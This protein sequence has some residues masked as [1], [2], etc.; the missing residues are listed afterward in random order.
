[1]SAGPEKRDNP[2]VKG[3]EEKRRLRLLWIILLASLGVHVVAGL[4]FGSI[5]VFRHIFKKETTFEAPPE[6]VRTIDP[7]KIEHKVKVREQQQSSGRPQVQ[8]RLAANKVSQ[9]SLP[10][11]DIQSA[12]VKD[13]LQDRITQNFATAGV[14]TGLGTGAGS[15]GLGT[16]SSSVNFFGLQASGER[17]AFLVDVSRSMVEDPKG[18]V[19]G[20]TVLKNEL[21]EMIDKLNDGTFFNVIFFDA[22]VDVLSSSKFLIAN[23]DNKAKAKELIDRY[24]E[25]AEYSSHEKVVG[26]NG[27]SFREATILR[28]FRPPGMESTK[29][30]I[31]SGSTRLDYA[32]LA[33]FQQKADTI[34][35]IADGRPELYRKLEGAELEEFEKEKEK[36]IK[37]AEERR[38]IFFKEL[39]KE[40]EKRAR[41]GLPPKIIEVP[42]GF[43]PPM[44]TGEESL[45]YIKMLSDEFYGKAR[46]DQPR[47]FCVAYAAEGDS[48]RFLRELSRD[49][50]GRFKKIRRLAKPIK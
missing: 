2:L 49:Y 38:A 10:E 39:E 9:I 19:P 16:G 31:N 44:M 23:K 18:G 3:R 30:K 36:K 21:K 37:A 22:Y 6:I 46:N 12:P 24:Y 28:N 43:G 15:G 8:P 34:F 14:G 5:V 7:R 35:V 11:I 29:F 25:P 4:I 40:N 47:I 48:E 27:T 17:I 50:R 32:L 45:E 26:A 1:M 20:Y 13:M 42:P 41:R 33:A